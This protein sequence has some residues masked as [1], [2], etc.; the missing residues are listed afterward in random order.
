MRKAIA[1]CALV[2]TDWA[3]RCRPI[4]LSYRIRHISSQREV[5]AI[6][7]MLSWKG[8]PR[9]KQLTINSTTQEHSVLIVDIPAWGT[10][11]AAGPWLHHVGFLGLTSESTKFHLHMRC[12]SGRSY[13]LFNAF[14]KTILPSNLVFIT[15]LTLRGASIPSV[16]SLVRLLQHFTQ[17]QCIV[18][19]SLTWNSH[20]QTNPGFISG[21]QCTRSGPIYIR[22]KA[23]LN[24]ENPQNTSRFLQ[25][26][27]HVCLSPNYPLYGLNFEESTLVC[28]LFNICLF[29]VPHHTQARH[30]TATNDVKT[31]WGM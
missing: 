10:S 4:L 31:I 15:E 25:L 21:P 23:G 17:L 14:P 1:Q 19:E 2:C 26:C 5:F 20:M 30:T 9:M 13:N 24:D 12:L 11:K 16:S 8:S 6:K 3:N 22:V 28:R 29:A 27:A 7:T 18:L